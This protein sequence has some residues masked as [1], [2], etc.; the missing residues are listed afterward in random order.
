MDRNELINSAEILGEN[1]KSSPE[2]VD[3]INS[4]K[5]FDDNVVLGNKINEFNLEKMFVKNEMDKENAD[6]EK[7]Q[8]HQGKIRELYN[9][10]TADPDYSDF[11]NK[12][13]E[14]NQLINDILNQITSSVTGNTQCTGSCETCSGCH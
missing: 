5:R 7:I 10:I 8:Q 11:Q 13:N 1:I 3:Y 6:E 9:D 14:L 2:Y 4:K 12:Q